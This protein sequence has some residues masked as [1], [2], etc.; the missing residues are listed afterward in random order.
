MTGEDAETDSEEARSPA[1][2]LSPGPVAL[3]QTPLVVSL[4]VPSVQWSK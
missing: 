2:G 1:Q 4:R 3:S